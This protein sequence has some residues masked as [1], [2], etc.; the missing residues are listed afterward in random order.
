MFKKIK[1]LLTKLFTKKTLT[2]TGATG[3]V[4]AASNAM[5]I[6]APV[7]GSF[8][9]TLYDYAVL[10]GIQGP[11]GFVGGIFTVVAGIALGIQNKYLPAIATTICGAALIGAPAIV[12]SMGCVF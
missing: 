4:M 8:A 3:L 9:Y 2:V 10:Q 12:T 7:A 5:A 11:L 1:K 6:T